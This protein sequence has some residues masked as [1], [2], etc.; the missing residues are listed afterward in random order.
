L[1]RYAPASVPD[2][3]MTLC[4]AQEFSQIKLRR[5]ERKLLKE[6]NA[7]D[8][9]IVRFKVTEARGKAGKQATSK[10]IRTPAA[11]LYSA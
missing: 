1:C 9:P 8:E 4:N 10:V 3:L 6:W 2:L 11:G 7:S 5:D